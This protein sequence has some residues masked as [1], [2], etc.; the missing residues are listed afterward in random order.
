MYILENVP[1]SAYSTMRLGGKAAYFTDIND[2]SEIAS[3]I[4]WA[5]ER[6]LPYIMIGNGSNIVWKDEGFAGLV[7]A[8]KIMHFETQ[9]VDNE[10]IYVTAGA[11]E[12]WDSIVKRT[13]EAGYSGIEQLSLIPG[14]TGGTPVQ[15]VGAYGRELSDVLITVEAY[16]RQAGMLVTLRGGDCGF[17][18]RTSRFKT[19]DRG[20]FF[21][22]AITMLLTR[23]PPTPPFYDSLAKYFSDNNITDY[24]PGAVR[25]AVVAIRSSKLPDPSVIANNGSF[26]CNPI[27]DRDQIDTL[28]YDYPNLAY[29]PVDNHKSKVSAAWLLEQAGFKDYHDEKTGMATWPKQPLVLINEHAQSTQDLLDFKQK[30]IDTV[31]EKFGIVLQQE[32]ELLP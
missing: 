29:W 9:E 30:I 32:P 1:L 21:I 19:N 13:V 23:I 3:A 12:N 11:G 31:K 14:T 25:D 5:E 17:G 24:T 15:N 8:N 22:S 28:L 6:Q 18:Y 10:N 27:I 7:M 4:S 26:F 2:R 16:D 20:R